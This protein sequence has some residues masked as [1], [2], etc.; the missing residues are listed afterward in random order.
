[1]G[2]RADRATAGGHKGPN[3]A[4]QPPPPLRETPRH[5]TKPTPESLVRLR[6]THLRS[7]QKQETHPEKDLYCHKLVPESILYKL[8]L[9]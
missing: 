2:N 8:L 3:P 5:G 6:L 9:S 7:V 4:P 1:M